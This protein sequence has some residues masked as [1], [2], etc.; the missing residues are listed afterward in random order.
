MPA[1]V[2]CHAQKTRSELDKQSLEPDV[3]ARGFSA[4][5]NWIRVPH[6]RMRGLAHG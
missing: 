1:Y 2:D 5:A 6:E 3:A 4:S